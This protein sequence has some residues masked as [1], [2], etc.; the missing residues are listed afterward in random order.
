MNKKNNKISSMIGLKSEDAI[1][2]S[3]VPL[4]KT[5]PEETYCLKMAYM[6]FISL[7][8]NTEIK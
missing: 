6:F 2:L 8:N 3:T 5:Y 4:D 1:K 7:G